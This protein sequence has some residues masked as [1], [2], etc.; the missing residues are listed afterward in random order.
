[1]DLKTRFAQRRLRKPNRVG[2]QPNFVKRFLCKPDITSANFVKWRLCKPNRRHPLALPV[3]RYACSGG[4]IKPE[5]ATVDYSANCCLG[6][7]KWGYCQ[8]PVSQR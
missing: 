7:P 6:L 4:V 5:T 1:M 8:V 3:S 2:N